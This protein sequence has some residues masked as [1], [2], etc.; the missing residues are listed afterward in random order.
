MWQVFDTRNDEHEKNTL[1]FFSVKIIF[2]EHFWRRN[3][4]PNM[5]NELIT[6]SDYS[7]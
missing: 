1:D 3:S 2:Q 4:W 5:L 6:N 7:G